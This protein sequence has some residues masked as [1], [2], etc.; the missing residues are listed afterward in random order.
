[1]FLNRKLVPLG[2]FALATGLL[3]GIAPFYTEF[4][5]LQHYEIHVDVSYA[6]FNTY[7][8]SANTIG[9]YG[10]NLVSCV[11][12]LNITNP[13]TETIGVTDITVGLVQ[14][15]HWDQEK[16]I[17][18]NETV[19][20]ER[21]FADHVTEYYW[22]PNSTRLIALTAT[23][24]LSNLGREAL[25]SG[26][27]YFLAHLMGRTQIGALASSDFVLKEVSLE[28]V[29]DNEYVYNSVFMRDYRFHFRNDELGISLE[30]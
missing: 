30:W 2:V 17:M 14:S 4:S 15:A 11:F 24:E 13:T 9:L 22:F 7:N 6:Y 18:E 27:G 19:Q 16:I 10:S 5:L 26:K 12:V 25:E 1:M 20:Y 3:T 8:A 23:G 29:S 28:R 21:S